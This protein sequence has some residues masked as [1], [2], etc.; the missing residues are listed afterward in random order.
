MAAGRGA[1]DRRGRRDH[2][3]VGGLRRWPHGRSGQKA[4]EEL[5]RNSGLEAVEMLGEGSLSCQA[6]R[7]RPGAVI[8][9][10]IGAEGP[11]TQ[12]DNWIISWYKEVQLRTKDGNTCRVL[13][14]GQTEKPGR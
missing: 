7:Q 9:G 5:P 11:S 4:A 14:C 12:F 10:T 2:S 6:L 8:V 1:G 3:L 13:S